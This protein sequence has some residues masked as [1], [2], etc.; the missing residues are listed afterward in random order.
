MRYSDN[1]FFFGTACKGLQVTLCSRS[2]AMGLIP[3]S[4]WGPPARR[5]ARERAILTGKVVDRLGRRRTDP[6]RRGDRNLSPLSRRKRT[7]V[8]I[9]RDVSDFRIFR[10][11]GTRSEMSPNGSDLTP[12]VGCGWFTDL[13]GR[14][15][16]VPRRCSG[17][18]RGGARRRTV[19]VA[20]RR[21]AS[22]SPTISQAAI[23][24]APARRKRRRGRHFEQLVTSAP[25]R[26]QRSFW[27][28]SPARPRRRTILL[29]TVSVRRS[30]SL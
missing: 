28:P 8:Q 14:R 4:P 17:G 15:P 1:R 11:V 12:A 29:R 16:S 3:D 20:P 23:P 18:G 6:R 21:R 25:N 30:G 24:L 26:A 2:F 22:P 13:A 7:V 27:R 9:G 5:R 10:R 19:D